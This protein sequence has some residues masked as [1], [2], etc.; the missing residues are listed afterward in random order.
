M[1]TTFQVEI[2]YC[3][4]CETLGVAIDGSPLTAHRCTGEPV[5]RFS[6]PGSP[7]LQNIELWLGIA[8]L[9]KPSKIDILE[10]A[11]CHRLGVA[12][13]DIR[14]TDHKCAG[15]WIVESRRRAMLPVTTL[16][17]LKRIADGKE[18]QW[19]HGT[20]QTRHKIA[21]RKQEFMVAFV[22]TSA[23]HLLTAMVRLVPTAERDSVHAF[24]KANTLTKSGLAEIWA[25]GPH[26]QTPFP[27]KHVTLNALNKSVGFLAARELAKT[28]P[29]VPVP[30]V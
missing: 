14:L 17:L 10:C 18:K 8:G 19:M 23:E 30:S 2:C 25:K 15:E 29:S 21:V 28:A 20:V 12:I 1:K 5:V 27:V 13:D 4:K 22:H 26:K 9:G 3:E 24:Y 16:K 7:S 11:K 6:Q